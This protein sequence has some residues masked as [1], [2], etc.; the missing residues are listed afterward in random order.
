MY[1]GIFCI[2]PPGIVVVAPERTLAVH[3]WV[4]FSAIGAACQVRAGLVCR[5]GLDRWFGF[6]VTLAKSAH[7]TMGF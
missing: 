7:M 3:C 5:G 1:L 6:E 2:D 4:T